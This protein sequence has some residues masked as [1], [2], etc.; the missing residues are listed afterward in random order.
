M[1]ATINQERLARITE[2]KLAPVKAELQQ[3]AVDLV[4]RMCALTEEK[5]AA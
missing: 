3:S 2:L 1:Q 4:K 5:L